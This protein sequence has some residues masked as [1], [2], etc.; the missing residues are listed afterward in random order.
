MSVAPSSSSHRPPQASGDGSTLSP[1]DPVN[2]EL[3][4]VIDSSSS[5]DEEEEEDDDAEASD[6][7]PPSPPTCDPPSISTNRPGIGANFA[8]KPPF[9]PKKH[10]LTKE[11]KDKAKRKYKVK[12]TKRELAQLTIVSG[13]KVQN[14]CTYVQWKKKVRSWEKSANVVWVFDKPELRAKYNSLFLKADQAI[15]I[16]IENAIVDRVVLNLVQSDLVGESGVRAIEELDKYFDLSGDEFSVDILDDSLTECRI[17]KGETVEEW[18]VRRSELEELLA[19]TDRKKSDNQLLTLLRKSIPNELKEVNKQL[20]IHSGAVVYSRTMYESALKSYARLIGYPFGNPGNQGDC[21]N[22]FDNALVN[23]S[24]PTQ[25][26]PPIQPSPLSALASLSLSPDQLTA[27][28][29]LLAANTTTSTTSNNKNKDRSRL[30]CSNCNKKGHDKESCWKLYPERKPDWVKTRDASRS[31]KNTNGSTFSVSQA[32]EILAAA[33]RAEALSKSNSSQ[34]VA[35]VSPAVNNEKKQIKWDFSHVAGAVTLSSVDFQKLESIPYDPTVWIVDSGSGRHVTPTKSLLHDLVMLGPDSVH[36]LVVADGRMFKIRGHGKLSIRVN[37]VNGK[38][39]IVTFPE[40]AWAP[41]FHFNLLS[42]SHIQECNG[43]VYFPPTSSSR[44]SLIELGDGDIN[45]PI[46]RWH[47]L[48]IMRALSDPPSP[49]STTL[50]A[51]AAGGSV[52]INLAHARLG[53][54]PFRSIK[55][56]V[57]HVDGLVIHDHAAPGSHKS[58]CEA[59][60]LDQRRQPIPKAPSLR[61]ATVPNVRVFSDMSGPFTVDGNRVLFRPNSH[62]YIVNFVDDCTRRAVWFTLPSKD[63]ASF[64]HC[65]ERYMTIVGKSMAILRTDDASELNSEACKEFYAMHGIRRELT[66]PGS[67]QF[68]GVAESNF[69]TIMAMGRKLRLHSG[70]NPSFGYLAARSALEVYNNSPMRSL[71]LGVTPNQAWSGQRSDLSALRVFGCKCWSHLN[72]DIL[73]KMG[74]RARSGIHVGLAQDS[75]GYLV[76]FPDTN[77]IASTRNIIFDES[78]FPARGWTEPPPPPSD[79][80]IPFPLFLPLKP[81]PSSPSRALPD[82]DHVRAV[83]P[84]DPLE[85]D[86]LD[87]EV[88]IPHFPMEGDSDDAII[89]EHRHMSSA[90]FIPV[91]PPSPTCPIPVED[92]MEIGDDFSP[93]SAVVTKSPEPGAAPTPAYPTVQPRRSDRIRAMASRAS[94]GAVSVFLSLVSICSLLFISLSAIENAINTVKGHSIFEPR[95]YKDAMNCPDA[96]EWIESMKREFQT[97]LA[98][99]TFQI[100]SSSEIPKGRKLLKAKWVYK[101]KTD[102][103]GNLASRKS[104]LVAKG[105]TEVPGVDF[106]EIF[107]P[108]GQGQTFR[109]LL[110]KALCSLLLIFHIDIKGAFLHANLKETIYMQLPPGTDLTMNGEVVVVRLLKS[111]YGLKQ[112]GREWYLALSTILLGLG[113]LQ[114]AVDPVSSYIHLKH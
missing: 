56:M 8:P 51:L 92:R 19:M 69:R 16:A 12:E 73:P 68:N 70:L 6:S 22:K 61:R 42:T 104:R 4:P 110:V 18:L 23:V 2:P 94:G 67:P 55:E 26:T 101:V 48:P 43:G 84:S 52:D 102:S 15:F 59:C 36:C 98:N 83:P 82:V 40:V 13:K 33:E 75:K 88:S 25:S 17:N 103:L 1:A 31:D 114:S 7:P 95:T 41:D 106:F 3:D 66:T 58:P 32:K 50:A 39:G 28:A 65:L 46:V 20:T 87:I 90:P 112:A 35:T 80:P 64:L 5:D 100:I 29:Q 37:D 47:N 97:L 54:K 49:P 93:P 53:H 71:P 99:N 85:S 86:Y 34:T 10:T 11:K 108:V 44:P 72:K 89:N 14:A 62:P 63:S 78:V 91:V 24:S 111:L 79:E 105:Y 77:R 27:V 30:Q 57:Q 96:A 21:P 113:F 107:H 45:I 38:S 74:A 60:A 81:S 76:Y 9:L 109:L